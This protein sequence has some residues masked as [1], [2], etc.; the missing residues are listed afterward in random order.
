MANRLKMA[1]VEAIVAL[2]A[3]GWSQRRIARELGVNRETVGRYLDLARRQGEAAAGASARSG[4][5]EVCPSPDDVASKPAK[6]PLGS[7]DSKPAKAPLGSGEAS[8]GSAGSKPATNPPTGSAGSGRTNNGGFIALRPPAHQATLDD[9][10]TEDRA[11]LGSDPSAAAAPNG[12]GG[13]LTGAACL[14]PVPPRSRSQCEPFRPMILAKLEQGLTAQRIYQDLVTEH[15]FAGQLLQ[16]AAVRARSWARRDAAAVPADGV[17][18]GRREPRWTSA[19]GRRSSVP[20]ASAGV[21]ARPAGRPEPLAARATARRSFRQSTDDFLRCLENAFW[22]FGGVPRTLVIDNLKA[23][24]KQADWFD[25]ELN[26]KVQAFC[27]ALRHG[28]PAHQAATR[29]GTRARSKRAWT[30][31]RTTA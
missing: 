27:R 22:H 31:S 21:D 19:P 1:M 7:G 14:S 20:T 12:T 29:P 26:P 17:C 13:I 25:P 30:T 2:V 9:A 16:R 23:A 6:A 3:R 4:V 8:L 10:A 11:T 5:G 18:A 24:V 15:G 28:D